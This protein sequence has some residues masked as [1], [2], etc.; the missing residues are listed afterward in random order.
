MQAQQAVASSNSHSS[1]ALPSLTTQG[2]AA[3]CDL[4]LPPLPTMAS[5]AAA[6][7]RAPPSA[8]SQLAPLGSGHV[9]PPPALYG[10]SPARHAHHL[11]PAGMLPA[12]GSATGMPMA[13]SDGSSVNALYQMPQ[14]PT[15]GLML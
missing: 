8:T 2:P 12:Q 13:G 15:S 4:P 6:T 11:G 7:L 3:P 9:P 1:S 10:M 5:V 14:H